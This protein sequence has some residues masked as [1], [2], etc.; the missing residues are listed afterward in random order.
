VRA[1]PTKRFALGNDGRFDAV[2][3]LRPMTKKLLA[4]L[5][6]TFAFSFADPAFARGKKGGGGPF[7]GGGH[8]SGSHGGTY[9]GASGSSHT[10]GKYI[11]PKTGNQYG[12]HK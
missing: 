5:A 3:E 2:G 8:H 6:L 10:G 9:K 7:Y 11:N 12:K 4:L 1:L